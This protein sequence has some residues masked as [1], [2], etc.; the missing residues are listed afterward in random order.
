MREMLVVMGGKGKGKGNDD[1]KM[2]SILE[3]T[4]K[5]QIQELGI[6]ISSTRL[7]ASS[8]DIAIG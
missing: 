2:F 6:T 4:S 7:I 3:F 8:T 1:D 5:Y